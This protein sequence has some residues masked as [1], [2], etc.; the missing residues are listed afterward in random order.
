MMIFNG[1]TLYRVFTFLEFV[2]GLFIFDKWI[3]RRDHYAVRLTISLVIGICITVFM[4]IG[5][6]DMLPN[7]LSLIAV[8]LIM[9]GAFVGL[10]FACYKDKVPN[11][12]FVGVACFSIQKIESLLDTLFTHFFPEAFE[13]INSFNWRFILLLIACYLV[14]AFATYFVF[15]K[16]M[17]GTTKLTVDKKPIIALIIAAV[18][19][20]LILN[21]LSGIYD[22]F[23]VDIADMEVVWNMISCALLLFVQLSICNRS[24]IESENAIVTKMLQE[25]EDQYRYSQDY[26]N[27]I[28][29]KSHNLKYALRSI[30][31]NNGEISQ[32]FLDTMAVIESYDKTIRTGSDALDIIVNEKGAYCKAHGIVLNPMIDGKALSIIKDVDI[33]VI[34]GNLIDNAIRAVDSI[35]NPTKREI[36]VK[37][38]KTGSMVNIMT[39][40]CFINEM[41]LRNG[42][43]ATTK[44]DKANHGFGMLSIKVIAEKYGGFMNVRTEDDRFYVCISIPTEN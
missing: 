23:G 16:N 31:K 41:V 17:K 15:R 14:V 28:N 12:L 4:P 39:E 7:T 20:D 2:F 1:Y 43:P 26:I 40:N 37:V 42:L 44:N 11:I 3:Q 22:I 5:L 24:K 35:E 36:Y 19:I 25:K 6:I 21:S 29:E 13:H 18:F 33:Y 32:E 34:F 27:N 10:L 38:N 9:F 30:I 8:F